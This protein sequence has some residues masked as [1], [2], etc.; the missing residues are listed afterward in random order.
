MTTHL[1]DHVAAPRW[2][3]VTPELD[4]NARS[5]P[6]SIPEL[7]PTAS[8]PPVA[9]SPREAVS[10]PVDAAVKPHGLRGRAHALGHALDAGWHHLLVDLHLAKDP[11]KSAAARWQAAGLPPEVLRDYPDFAK[12]VLDARLHRVL[13]RTGSAL[14]F[15]RE[16]EPGLLVNGEPTP[17]SQLKERFKVENGE[18]HADGVRWSYMAR[19][20]TPHHPE[21]WKVAQPYRILPEGQRPKDYVFQIATRDKAKLQDHVLG[22]HTW[23]RVIAPTGEVYSMGAGLDPRTL[24]PYKLSTAAG[25][26]YCPDPNEFAARKV[27]TTDTSIDRE[28]FE[29][30][31]KMCNAYQRC[32]YAFNFA[33][34]NCSVF[35]AAM[36][37]LAGQHIDTTT[38]FR[39]LWIPR[40]LTQALPDDVRNTL[41]D[42]LDVVDMLGPNEVGNLCVALADGRWDLFANRDALHRSLQVPFQQS[43]FVRAPILHTPRKIEDWQKQQA[44]VS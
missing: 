8:V 15:T 40:Q 17:W 27:Y 42:V 28:Q 41:R 32:G 35:V 14:T 5:A 2:S 6:G 33:Q 26:I 36:A 11:S 21:Q 43:D 4:T 12:L 29:H 38:R 30:I 31:L 20:L 37:E 1:L 3:S 39:D 25:G 23:I 44:T 7:P 22:T 16:G 10:A 24:G 13:Q 9:P 18:L 19:G 34:Q